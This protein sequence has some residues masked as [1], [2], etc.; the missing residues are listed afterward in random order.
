MGSKRDRVEAMSHDELADIYLIGNDGSE[1][2]CNKAFL[3][4]QS[5][6]F[7]RMF[8]KD[9]REQASFD[10]NQV[11]VLRGICFCQGVMSNLFHF[12]YLHRLGIELIT[13]GF[14]LLIVPF[15]ITCPK[16]F[17]SFDLG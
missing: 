1:V 17:E 6:V 7:K 10:S 5:P 16:I 4:A 15:F 13:Q 14:H 9:F 3:A 12:A 11:F 2:A 8:F